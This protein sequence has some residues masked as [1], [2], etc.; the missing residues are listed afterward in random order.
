MAEEIQPDDSQF[1]TEYA[2]VQSIYVRSRNSLLLRADFSP[3]FV[4]Y[5]LHLMQHGI[6]NHEPEDSLFKQLLAFF[7][8][9]LVSR[10]WK[11][12]HAWTFNVKHPS[13]ANYFM[14]GSSLTED[15]VGRIFTNDV[16]TTE[17]DMLY[18]QNMAQGREVH[19]SVIPLPEGD[20]ATW[21][22]AF[23]RQS[24][25]R[26]ARALV[27]KGDTYALVVA[28]PGAD[29]DWI[30]ELRAEQMEDIEK[31]ED[32]KLLETRR[33]TF[34]CGCTPERILPAIRAMHKDFAD[35]LSEQ[36]KLDVSCPR[37]GV[38]YTITPDMIGGSETQPDC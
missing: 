4:G 29:H 22:E 16:R 30:S 21:I 2:T 34:R 1:V 32:V 13:I 3:L 33:Y 17:P 31:T 36:G 38:N 5:Y 10:P 15:V 27:G 19:T 12:H 6:R 23:Y 7:T 8:L 18:A 9:Y 35:I 11:E 37:C 20:G 25:Q 14:T 24:E 26:T 28:Q